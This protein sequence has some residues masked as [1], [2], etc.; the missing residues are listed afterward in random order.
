[1]CVSLSDTVGEGRE[2][3]SEGAAAEKALFPQVS[4]ELVPGG[5]ECGGGVRVDPVLG[6][7]HPFPS[8]QPSA[9]YWRRRPGG[10]HTRY[11]HWFQM[12]FEAV[13][14]HSRVYI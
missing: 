8:H 13:R 4:P 5:S 6:V 14:S 7:L 3:Q 1:M 10:L 12:Y 9:M 2:F 11:H